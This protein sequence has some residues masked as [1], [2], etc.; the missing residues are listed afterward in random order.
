MSFLSGNIKRREALIAILI[1]LCVAL[2]ATGYAQNQKV[3]ALTLQV[4]AS[5]HK[6]LYETGELMTGV[7]LGLEKLLVSGSATGRQAL[8]SGI[9]READGVCE[10]LAMLPPDKETYDGA[11][12]FVNQVGDYARVLG[13]RL[14]NG[15]AL[16]PEDLTQVAAMHESCVKLNQYLAD[17][18]ARYE[19][20]DFDFD[21]AKSAQ[22]NSLPTRADNEVE[23][24]ISYPVMLYD[25]PF[26]DARDTGEVKMG[27][28]P[29]SPEQAAERLR[30]FIGAERIARL[31]PAGEST[32]LSACY[33]FEAETESGTLSAGVSKAGGHVVYMLPD[34]SGGT[35]KLSWAECIDLG[36]AFLASRGYRDMQV[37]YWQQQGAI[38][39]VN[40]AAMQDGVILYPDLIKLQL[41][42]ENGLVVGIEAVNYLRNHAP[43][44]LLAPLIPEEKAI[45]AMNQALM[46]EQIRPCVIPLEAGE[47]QCWE[48]KAQFEGGN[49]YLIYL[50]TQTGAEHTILQIVENGDGIVTQ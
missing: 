12:K 1:V 13:E 16:T 49:R 19:S 21:P 8:L 28:A 46:I 36:Q 2:G 23:P 24:L 3:E 7:Q 41:S 43:R 34:T 26:S 6:A 9:A 14:A 15:G 4:S 48:V 37:S 27:G 42:M 50:D 44:Q 40:Y 17:K 18:I 45:A 25:G 20:G 47:A 11:I 33:E 5:Y 22:M 10:N 32:I 38:L 39:T 35:P 31:T 29:V 30:A